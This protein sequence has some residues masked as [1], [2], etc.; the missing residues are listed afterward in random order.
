LPNNDE[1]RR[2]RNGIKINL[3]LVKDIKEKKYCPLCRMV[4]YSLGGINHDIPDIDRADGQPVEVTMRWDVP[5]KPSLLHHKFLVPVLVPRASNQTTGDLVMGQGDI[6]PEIK[7]LA[8]DVPSPSKTSFLRLVGDQIDFKM[9]RNWLWLCQ[10]WHGSACDKTE[11]FV[12]QIDD[13]ATNIPHFRLIDTKDNCVVLAPKGSTYVAL[14]YVWGKIDPLRL[15]KTN[16]EKLA[17]PGS[18]LLPEN[19]TGVPVTI[20]DAM[21]VVQKLHLRYLWVDSLCIVQDDNGPDGS[22]MGAISKMDLVYGGAYL[23]IMAATGID[24]NTGLPGLSPG[25]RRASQPVEEIYPG[26][27]LGCMTTSRQTPVYFTRAWT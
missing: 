16:V 2:E 22:K 12:S 9:V 23:T 6:F 14:S 13:P 26:L 17:T 15:L 4:L 20:R 25:T 11:K 5:P 19:N 27:R 3:G 7:M 24:A 8:N 10:K 18:L 21:E 1:E